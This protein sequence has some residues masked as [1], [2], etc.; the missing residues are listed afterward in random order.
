MKEMKLG[1]I[2]AGEFGNFASEVIQLLPNARLV[3]VADTNESSALELAKINGSKIYQ[4]YKLLLADT[5]VE[6]VLINTPNF[7]HAEMVIAAIKKGKKVLCEKPLGINREELNRVVKII[8]QENGILLVNFLLP[9]SSL[10]KKIQEIIVKKT[11]GKL[12]YLEIRNLATESTIQSKWYW[13][14][15]KSG[16]WFLTADVHF[17]DLIS[18]IVSISPKKIISSEYSQNGKI[19][20]IFTG[21]DYDG[22]IAN[23]FHDFNAGYERAGLTANFVFQEAEI[24]VS[25]WVPTSIKIKTK[26][27]EN[28]IEEKLDREVVYR[29]LV[30]DNISKLSGMTSEE[31]ISHLKRVVCASEIALT[32]Q[33]QATQ[34]EL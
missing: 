15:S 6:I 31:T 2:G 28:I 1:L 12:L 26:E 29:Q 17:Y 25:G 7:L 19:S 5:D 3:A 13:D 4:D 21:I 10:Y 14:K 11:Y 9:D 22:C 32:A 16:G 27:S 24:E 8:E 34:I 18:E 30:A 23:I 20:A 33:D